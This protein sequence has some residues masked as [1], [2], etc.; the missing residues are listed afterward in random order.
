M[1]YQSLIYDM[2]SSEK[3]T[4]VSKKL[5]SVPFVIKTF[6]FVL[7]LVKFH[8]NNQLLVELAAQ[9]DKFNGKRKGI[10]GMPHWDQ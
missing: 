6:N 7:L 5:V 2:E 9:R 1:G 10:D 4:G 3:T 8:I